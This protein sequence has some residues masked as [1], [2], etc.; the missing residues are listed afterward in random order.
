MKKNRL[1]VPGLKRTR[2]WVRSTFKMEDTNTEQCPDY[3]E[4]GAFQVYLGD[5][6][7]AKK[8]PEHLP[9]ANAWERFGNGVRAISGFLGSSESAFGFRV[10]CATMT[11]GIVAYLRDTQ[12]FFVTQRLVW[13]MIMVAIGMTTTAGSGVFSFVGR[14]AGTT[15]A[16][17]TSIVMWYI[18]DQKTGFDYPYR[19]LTRKHTDGT[20]VESSLCSGYLSSL[21]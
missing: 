18:V 7:R 1:I 15:I 5:S 21:V 12:S 6:L 20:L 4:S 8:D 11:I 16:M 13:A 17:C 14:I 3:T 9:V 10:A 19:V 2:K